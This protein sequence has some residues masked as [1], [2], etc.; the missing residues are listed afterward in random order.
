MEEKLNGITPQHCGGVKKVI[1]TCGNAD[2]Y[3][4]EQNKPMLVQK[5]QRVRRERKRGGGGRN[6]KEN[7]QFNVCFS[8]SV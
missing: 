2:K 3:L 8:I 6:Q 5:N 4:I 7:P 1:E